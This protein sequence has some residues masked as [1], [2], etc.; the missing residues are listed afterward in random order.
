M[1]TQGNENMTSKANNGFGAALTG[2]FTAAATATIAACM[3]HAHISAIPL[4]LA[5]LAAAVGT[6][7]WNLAHG[8]SA[9]LGIFTLRGR[10]RPR[11]R[12]PRPPVAPET[13]SSSAW[14]AES[15]AAPA[16]ATPASNGGA[17]TAIAIVL[18]VLAALV[19]WAYVPWG[20]PTA[21]AAAN[22]PK[23]ASSSVRPASVVYAYY[24]AV[25]DREWPKAWAL[26]GHPS[27]IG[28]AAYDYW[29]YGYGCTLRD[30]IT[31][32]TTRGATVL[33]SVRAQESGG[34]TQS[35]RFSY[36][37]KDGILTRPQTLSITGGAPRGCGK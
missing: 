3:D 26:V 5:A 33:V 20:E 37:V 21:G 7:T 34:L 25:N 24:A 16:A 27:A 15:P 35:Y 10:K 31:G 30:Q 28:S 36:V 2:I 29:A 17:A 4:A 19:A 22:S 6:T 32:I 18:I 14:G 13:P 8:G 11:Q 23:K 12:A 9:S 1:S